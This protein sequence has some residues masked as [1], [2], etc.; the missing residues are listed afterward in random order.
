VVVGAGPNGLGAAIELATEGLSVLVV[1]A[2]ARVGGAAR[3]AELTL[4][5]FIHDLGSAIHPLAAASP[6]FARLRLERQGLGWVMPPLPLAHP[7]DG[8]RAAV[9]ARSI[10]LTA[11]GLGA[12]GPQY[13]RLFGPLVAD[14]AKW[15]GSI[16]AP[17]RPPRHPLALARFGALAIRPARWLARDLFDGE[18]ARALFAGTAAHSILPLESPASGAYG[19]VLGAIGH[20]VGWPFPRGGAGRISEAL[21]GCL[22]SLGGEILTGAPVTSIEE[23]PP[24]RAVLFDTSPRALARVAGA[25]LPA[26]FRGKLERYR[27]GPGAFKLD[28]ALNGPIPWEAP[29]C[30]RAGTVHLGGSLAEIAASERAVGRGGHPERPWVLLAQNSLFDPTRAPEGKHTV[31]AYCHVPNG[32]DFDMT[33]RI[34]AQVERFAPGFRDRILAR[35]VSPPAELE[36][37]NANLVGG[38]VAGGLGDP[39]HLLGRPRFHHVPYATPAPGIYL[40][41]SSA[42]PGGAVHGLCGYYAARAALRY[43]FGHARGA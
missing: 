16:F 29:E 37:Q 23:L 26:R 9:Q 38:D 19:L 36:R 25:R 6:F 5:G 2:N 14:H 11:A 1:E 20:S 17:M 40:C 42:P 18:G 30:G 3:S 34:E 27:H 22:R 35:H 33:D 8:G 13:R 21:A 39:L 24:A 15:F 32:S 10:E 43:S 12:D 28:W 31:W 7:L 41:S 4:P